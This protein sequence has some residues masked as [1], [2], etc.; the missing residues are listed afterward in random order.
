[1]S[2]EIEI[3]KGRLFSSNYPNY[4]KTPIV[5]A[6]DLDETLGCFTDLDILWKALQLYCN[7]SFNTISQYHGKNAFDKI[8]DNDLQ[9]F[10]KLLDLYPEFLRYGILSILEFLN[11]KKKRGLCDKIYIYTNNQCTPSWCKLI[12]NYFNYKLNTDSDIFDHFIYAFK[13]NN[14]IIEIN[15]TTHE[16]THT[17]FIKCTLL[18][19]KTRLC[20]IDNTYFAE[21]CN[22]NVYYIQPVSYFHRLPINNIIDRFLSSSLC[23]EIIPTSQHYLLADFLYVQ[24][25]KRGFNNTIMVSKQL[26]ENDIFVAQKI[27]Y[28]IKDFFYIVQKKRKTK[29]IKYLNG[30]FTRKRGDRR[31]PLTPSLH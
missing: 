22:D 19:K 4:K 10:N 5:I 16:K 9:R 26:L 15:R 23:S 28:H 24:F 7:N 3:Y 11:Q 18:P 12:A 13:I 2:Y 31:F 27:M 30:R 17:D 20:F 21:M 1:M 29:K 25:E 8:D 6:F 14:K